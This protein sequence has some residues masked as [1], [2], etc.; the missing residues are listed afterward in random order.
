MQP[1][2]SSPLRRDIGSRLFCTT[3]LSAA[4]FTAHRLLSTGIARLPLCSRGVLQGHQHVRFS[5]LST[6]LPSFSTH[7]LR[8]MASTSAAAAPS[9]NT[10]QPPWHAPVPRPGEEEP[11]F[12]M[13]NSLTR[14][15]VDFVPMDSRHVTWYSCGPTVYDASHLG[16]ARCVAW[17]GGGAG[18]FERE[19][20]S[21]SATPMLT[22]V[23]L[24]LP[25]ATM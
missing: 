6:I 10:K 24:T 20:V 22:A 14:S 4:S 25:A 3:P 15:K 12:K 11:A 18:R 8:T 1:C 5:P 2:F 23:C 7:F 17:R 9:A 19:T 16:H 21:S 13:Y